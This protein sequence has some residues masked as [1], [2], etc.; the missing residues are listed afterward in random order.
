MSD[1]GWL[2]EAGTFQ[3][4]HN[5]ELQY[6]I[7]PEARAIPDGW[8]ATGPSGTRDACLAYIEATWTD[9]RPRSLREA[10]DGT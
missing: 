9:M 7:W 3:V 6:S 5:D 10:M 4:V 8:H 1:P 2:D